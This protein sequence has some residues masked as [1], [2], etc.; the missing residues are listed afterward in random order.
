[1][2]NLVLGYCDKLVGCMGRGIPQGHDIKISRISASST[3]LYFK[4]KIVEGS[5][6][7]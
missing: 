4:R 7:M 5:H 2:I 6:E 3:G 1:M